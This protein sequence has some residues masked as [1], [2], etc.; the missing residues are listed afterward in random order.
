MKHPIRKILVPL[1]PS[2]YS[3]N[4]TKQAC[5]V[6]R[7]HEARVAGLTILDT[8]E[9]Q[10]MAIPSVYGYL[11][12]PSDILNFHHKHAEEQLHKIQRRFADYCYEQKV[13]SLE[14]E[15]EGMPV[16]LIVEAATLFDLMVVGMRTFFRFETKNEDGNLVTKIFKKSS[17][18]VLAVTKDYTPLQNVLIAYDGSMASA[19]AL[20]DFVLFADPLDFSVD[21]FVADEDHEK[22]EYNA[23]KAFFYLTDNGVIINNIIKRD[24]ELVA[25]DDGDFKNYDIIVCG[26]HSKTAITEFFVGSFVKTLIEK[27]ENC[28]FLSH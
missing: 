3:V 11:K 9:I 22:R 25:I 5:W 6:A 14:A 15:R 26:M 1:D 23:N 7:K 19:R 28:L 24:H 8:P 2:E 27:N 20:R 12:L 10:A 16:N 17:T 18:P 13:E 21:L 4:A